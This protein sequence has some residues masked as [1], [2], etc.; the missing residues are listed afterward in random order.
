MTNA[1]AWWSKPRIT[2]V[3][4][5]NESWILPYANQ[6]VESLQRGGDHASLV[7]QH[8]DVREG[9]V[10]F[11]LGCVK[12]TPKSIL[13]RNRRNLV[14]HA[15]NLPK[16]RGFS[17]M[18]WLILEGAMRIPVCLIEAADEVDAGDVIYRE[19]I[20]CEGHELND[21]LRA[22]LGEMH[23]ALCS[24]FMSQ[25]TPPIG[26]PQVG[27]VTRYRRRTPTDSR[28]D[29]QK[30][31][32]EQFDLLRVVDNQRYPAFFDLRGHRYLLKIEKAPE[33]YGA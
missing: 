6:L 21:A 27:D 16:G 10:A 33:G 26:M 19:F 9:A 5:D 22:A 18:V 29:P 30:T 31:L 7:R 4:V 15:S 1:P 11:Y 3:V 24:R 13:A 2:S 12:I 8:E 17:P 25:T 14:V 28:M 23:V 32:A 20:D